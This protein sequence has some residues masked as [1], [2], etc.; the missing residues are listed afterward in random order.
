M[1]PDIPNVFIWTSVWLENLP[2][3]NQIQK[4]KITVR[5]LF[6]P[7]LLSLIQST[8]ALT[9]QGSPPSSEGRRSY[10]SYRSSS[11][12]ASWKAINALQYDDCQKYCDCNYTWSPHLFNAFQRYVVKKDM[13][14][15]DVR[16]VWIWSITVKFEHTTFLKLTLLPLNASKQV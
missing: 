6:C 14:I 3:K 7:V 5:R 4:I 16:L 11:S 13:N 12:I 15:F 1:V 9:W 2:S 10:R 8:Y